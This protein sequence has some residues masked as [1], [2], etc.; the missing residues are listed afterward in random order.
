M[1]KLSSMINVIQSTDL[2]VQIVIYHKSLFMGFDDS[3]IYDI[4]FF[5]PFS[6]RLP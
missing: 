6:K 5:W 1:Q 4:K 2:I 3:L